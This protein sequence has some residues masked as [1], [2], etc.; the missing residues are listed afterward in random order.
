MRLPRS[1]FGLA[2]LQGRLFAVGGYCGISEIEHVECFDPMGNKWTDVNGL[3]KARMS[4]GVVTYGERI[5]VIGGSNSVGV[6]DSIEK[7]NPDLNIWLIIRN[8]MDPRSGA[9]VA[10]VYGGDEGVQDLYIIGGKDH[11]GRSISSVKKLNL[12]FADYS[13]AT[14]PPLILS[15]AFAGV[16]SV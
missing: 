8:T 13:T 12:K 16:A 11:H 9:A 15:R 2:A 5:Y 6:L 4:H 14:A 10:A 3:N 1:N 7:Y